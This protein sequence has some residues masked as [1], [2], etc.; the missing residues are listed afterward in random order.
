MRLFLLVLSLLIVSLS[1]KAQTPTDAI[2][3]DRNG[4]GHFRNIQQAIDSVRA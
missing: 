2:V 1:A 3:V 4:T